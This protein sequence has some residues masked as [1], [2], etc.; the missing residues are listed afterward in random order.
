M[1]IFPKVCLLT[2]S[3]LAQWRS[4]GKKPSC[5]HHCH[6]ENS[7]L[8][9]WLIGNCFRR[10]DDHTLVEVVDEPDAADEEQA[11]RPFAFR[12]HHVSGGRGIEKFLKRKPNGAV[13]P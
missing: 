2:V 4:D 9:A 12:W 1:A 5:E 13:R 10:V 11:L 3:Q 8:A 7:K 6:I